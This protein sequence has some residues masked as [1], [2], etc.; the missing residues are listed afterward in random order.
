MEEYVNAAQKVDFAYENWYNG[1]ENIY[2]ADDGDA[3]QVEKK[4]FEFRLK[5]VS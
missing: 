2:G 3:K 5:T 4:M 1:V